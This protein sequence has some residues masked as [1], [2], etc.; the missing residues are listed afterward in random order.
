MS[1]SPDY[2][3]VR[4]LQLCAVDFTARSF[5]LPIT[6]G[7]LAHGMDVRIGCAAAHYTPELRARGYRV[8][9]VEMARAARPL[10]QLRAF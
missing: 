4:V 2:S 9:T 7:L 5:L 10:A 3:G 8:D 1:D 6:D